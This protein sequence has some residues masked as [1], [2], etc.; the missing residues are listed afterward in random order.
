[1]AT[2]YKLLK[3]LVR[4]LYLGDTDRGDAGRFTEVEEH[5]IT[6]TGFV[7][8]HKGWDQLRR[9]DLGILWE[10]LVMNELHGFLHPRW[11]HYWRSKNGNEV[12]LVIAKRDMPLIVIECKWS[13]DDLDAR[14]IRAFGNRYEEGL[15]F[16]VSADVDRDFSKTY[17]KFEVR[18]VGL[19]RLRREV[20]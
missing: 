18:F 13:A 6:D 5:F 4:H 3:F 9:E 11:I 8:Y 7:W 1:M 10:H 15:N 20:S 14:H 12:D 19:P 16:V 2:G 17:G